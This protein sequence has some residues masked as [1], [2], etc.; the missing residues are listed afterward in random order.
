[1]AWS[2]GTAWIENIGKK[3]GQGLPLFCTEHELN[4]YSKNS[5]DYVKIFM[6]QKTRLDAH[7]PIVQYR[8][9]MISWDAATMT[10]LYK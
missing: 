5:S 4:K 3:V 10:S 8:G 1:M 9:N 2:L 6:L 7:N